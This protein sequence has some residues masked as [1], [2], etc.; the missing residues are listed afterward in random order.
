MEY[1]GR[2]AWKNQWGSMALAVILTGALL[3]GLS[4]LRDIDKTGWATIILAAI[5]GVFY[6][7]IVYHHYAWIF[8][9][10]ADSIESRYG[11]IARNIKSI[12]VRDLRNV[13]L[14]QSIFQ[15]ILGIGDLEF[16]TAGGSGIEVSFFGI[17][18]PMKLKDEIQKLQDQGRASSAP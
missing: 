13:N 18:N 5:L 14:R 6:L 3:Y 9:V 11:L 4:Y 7:S 15:R 17:E 8:T 1:S 2:P 10:D 16:S 12:R